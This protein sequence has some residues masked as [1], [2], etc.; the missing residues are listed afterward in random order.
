M[1]S[2]AILLTDN[3]SINEQLILKSYKKLKNSKLKKIFLIGDKKL[4]PKIYKITQNELR[5]I[6]F[7]DIS[8]KKKPLNYLKD[9]T[10]Y[11]IN[12]F[13]QKKINYL[14]NMPLNKRKFLNNKYPGYTEFFSH[15]INSKKK[16]NML[17]FN[18]KFSVCP[19]TTHILLK[20][21]EKK[22]NKIML[23]KS[24]IN[25]YKFYKL[26]IKKKI[27]IVVLGLNPH[28]GK[29]LKNSKDNILINSVIKNFNNKIDITGPISPD[30]AFSN[31][32]NKVFIGMYHDQVLIPFKMI[33][34]FNG[35]N[36]TIGNKLIRL[37]PDHG[38]AENI[39]DKKRLINNQS[40]LECIKFCEK[41]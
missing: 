22:L 40:F 32:N 3:E 31:L 8:Y 18:D 13:K 33:N 41:Y 28:A 17:L 9:I 12:L 35:V 36:I 24:I 30:T 23:K 19:L 2:I 27:Q 6:N 7:N 29:D 14:I 10:C 11:A 1:K 4:F 5:K 20:N 25:I 34:K 37:S 26:K 16:T 39:K 21:V 15:M 38:T